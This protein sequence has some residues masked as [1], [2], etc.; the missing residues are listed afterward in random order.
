MDPSHLLN[1]EQRDVL[2]AVIHVV[3]E[4][5]EVT[6]GPSAEGKEV[7]QYDGDRFIEGEVL[8]EIVGA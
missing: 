3:P 7:W 4:G 8:Q 2:K 6:W 5:I 1:A